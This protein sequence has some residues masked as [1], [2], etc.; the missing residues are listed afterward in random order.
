[1]DVL[2]LSLFSLDL[3]GFPLPIVSSSR[4]VWVDAIEFARLY[5]NRSTLKTWAVNGDGFDS[6][7]GTNFHYLFST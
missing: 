2:F 3:Y 1:M 5:R 7:R 4:D 6:Y